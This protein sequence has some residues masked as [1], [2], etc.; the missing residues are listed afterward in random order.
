MNESLGGFRYEDALRLPK[1]DL[2]ALI[3][4]AASM[5]AIL[6]GTA[7]RLWLLRDTAQSFPAG[8]AC[9]SCQND[10]LPPYLPTYLL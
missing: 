7:D 3:D 9:R 8:D 1:F 6:F 4:A 2:T 10:Y 5:S